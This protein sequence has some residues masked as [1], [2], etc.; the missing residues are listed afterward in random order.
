MNTETRRNTAK[1]VLLETLVAHH[2]DTRNR[3]V[4]RAI[5]NLVSLNPTEAPTEAERLLEGNWLLI[6]APIFPN[7]LPD[8]HERYIYTLGRL[9]FNMFE[10]TNLKIA[11][12]RVL[13]PVFSTG[14][15]NE[16]THDIVVEF[17]IIDD[18]FPNLNGIVKNLAV[19]S[20]FDRDTLQ[21]RFTGGELMPQ[22]SEDPEELRQWLTV[23]SNSQGKSSLNIGEQIKSYLI[24][25]MFGIQKASDIDRQT[26]KRFFVMK[27]SP[28]G[29]LQVLY[30]DDEL[31]ITKG[32]RE[33]MLVC[34]RL[35]N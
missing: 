17:E 30:L 24:K 29:K 12:E 7:R 18:R 20:P 21:V 3:E 8:K 15:G 32:N 23:F 26:G 14:K 2:G 31:R 25:W 33:T 11:I 34:Q 6:N 10:P 4:L 28:Q 1:A 27:K 22:S 35:T 19:C 5:E 9:A 16:R 13:Q